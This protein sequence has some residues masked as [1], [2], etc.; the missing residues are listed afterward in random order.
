MHCGS[1]LKTFSRYLDAKSERKRSYG[2][3]L[4]QQNQG[5]TYNGQVKRALH[6]A[7]DTQTIRRKRYVAR[8]FDPFLVKL[9]NQCGQGMIKTGTVHVS[10]YNHS[11]R[12]CSNCKARPLTVSVF[13]STLDSSLRLSSCLRRCSEAMR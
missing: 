3:T 11:T 7:R 1:I 4:G 5:A 10:Q 6:V 13:V 12:L 8:L 2:N 9:P